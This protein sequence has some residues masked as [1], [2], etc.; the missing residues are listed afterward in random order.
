MRLRFFFIFAALLATS[1][2][3]Y[4]QSQT[5]GLQPIPDKLVVLTFDDSVK[6]HYTVARPILKEYGFGATFFITEGFTFRTN[7]TD[8]MTWEEIRALHD[9]GFEIGNH[10]R[11]H[12]VVT[13]EDVSFV[14]GR[15]EVITQE[16][17]SR[18]GEQVQAI[19]DRARSY[20][21]PLT[22]SFAFPGNFVL[23]DPRTFEMLR[24]AGIL[25]A[26]RGTRPEYF[27]L[28][29]VRIGFAYEP[30]ADHPLLIPSAGIPNPDCTMEDFITSVSMARDGKIAILQFHGVPEGEHP[31]TSV[32]QQRFEAFM[33][34]LHDEGYTVIAMRDLSRYVDPHAVPA[35]HR[36]VIERSLAQLGQRN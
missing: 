21:I 9:D 34:Y 23:D 33:K 8:Y 27:G 13:D 17:L 6:S 3:V 4:G 28:D 5:G 20:G 16:N 26:R 31:F 29:F 22:V 19:N 30:G 2:L 18:L 11:D 24:E 15:F 32:P 7:K 12:I 1:A 14:R 36:A 10:T 35:D 25:W